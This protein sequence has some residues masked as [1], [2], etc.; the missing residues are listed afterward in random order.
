MGK[1]EPEWVN[2]VA[3]SISI[4]EARQFMLALK[5]YGF[6]PKP[7]RTEQDVYNISTYYLRRSAAAYSRIHKDIFREV[8]TACAVRIRLG[9]IL[10]REE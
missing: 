7:L 8:C 10:K 6:D 2:R 5:Q 9:V 3:S 4:T 1:P